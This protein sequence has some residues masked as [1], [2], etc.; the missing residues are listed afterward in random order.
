LNN[1]NLYIFNEFAKNMHR[2]K[3]QP[4]N[5][6]E[7]SKKSAHTDILD[8][9]EP[10]C[11]KCKSTRKAILET[12]CPIIPVRRISSLPENLDDG[13]YA[14]AAGLLGVAVMFLPED[15]RDV[16]D[17]INQLRGK[18]KKSYDFREFQQPFSYF[19]GTLMEP[20]LKFKGKLGSKISDK[21]Q[22]WDIPIYDTKFGRFLEK[23][24]NIKRGNESFDTGKTYGRNKKLF[25][26]NFKGNKA[27]NL[28]G[29]ALLRI[30][31][32]SV[33]TLAV[34]ELPAIVK[35]LNTGEN[36]QEKAKN[37]SKQLA[38]S[39]VY[40]TSL[41]AGVGLCGAFLAKKGPAG[42]LLGM[43]VGAVA[44]SRISASINNQIDKI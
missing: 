19:K 43:G 23:I 27:S 32:L 31:Y 13:N 18:F 9:Y 11:L 14:R 35:S 5:S 33:L 20:L 10:E 17:G 36:I 38:K 12:L 2:Q 40:V 44:G 41:I 29:R 28:L 3:N 1:V 25:A 26:Y 24:F 4:A 15:C 6:D 39:F 37:T 42:S 34:L 30:P 8:R 16:R 22:S 21:L 7:K